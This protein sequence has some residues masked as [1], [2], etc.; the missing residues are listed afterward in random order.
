MDGL[1]Q[2][3][4]TG[5]N[6]DGVNSEAGSLASGG[7]TDGVPANVTTPVTS[8]AIAD[9]KVGTRHRKDMGDIPGLAE[10]IRHVGLLHP[11]VVR[12]DGTLIAGGRRLAAFK[13]LE[14]TDIP[15]TVVDLAAIARGEY[16]ENTERKDFTW[17]EA[18][19]IKRALEPMEKAAAKERQLSGL[20]KGKESRPGNLPGRE[21]GEARDK[22]AK[23]TGK[24]ARSLAKAEAVVQAAEAEPEKF[25]KLVEDMDRTG[26]VDGP[27]KRL[28]VIKQ[29][30]AIRAEPPPYPNKGPYRVIVAD[31]P[32]AYEKRQEDPSHRGVLPYTSMSIEQICAEASKVLAIA[33]DDCLLWLWTTN[34]HMRE[35]FEVLDA[36]GFQQKTIL[37][38][39]KDKMGLGDWL[40]GQT[41]HCLM[42]VRGSPIVHL[43]NQTT[44][45]HGPMREHSRKPDE[46]YALVE[47]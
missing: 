17:S 20:K 23:A 13:Y 12:P 18:V 24:K 25:G 4:V 10:T 9:I 7:A 3:P 11:I 8:M 30:A 2:S 47:Q 19:E 16:V 46:F 6:A 15:V 32:W 36:W 43:T 34:H 35:A 33:H 44:V 21:K 5:D 45:L 22:A 1:V 14:R 27:H 28:K 41:E 31:P 26:R 39:A 40:R 38:W 37:T 42:A 29:A